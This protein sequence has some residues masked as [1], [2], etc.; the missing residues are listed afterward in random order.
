MTLYR[1]DPNRDWPGGYTTIKAMLHRGVLVEVETPL[2]AMCGACGGHGETWPDGI[3]QS[4][5]VCMQVGYV[6]YGEEQDG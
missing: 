2:F 5:Q 1:I 3:Q 4:C 6:R